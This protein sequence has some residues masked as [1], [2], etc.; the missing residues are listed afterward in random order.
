[1]KISYSPAQFA[2]IGDFNAI[3]N[4]QDLSANRFLTL[5][6]E[7]FTSLK[8]LQSLNLAENQVEDINGLLTTQIDLKWLNISSN[9]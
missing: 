1:M 5:E 2:E 4:F 6:Q 9:R 8:H 3:Y 7:I